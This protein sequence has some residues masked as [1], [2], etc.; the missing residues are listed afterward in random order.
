MNIL[1]AHYKRDDCQL[2]NQG[3]ILLDKGVHP[4]CIL[5]VEGCN[6]EDCA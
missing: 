3:F 4:H 5:G 6:V 1:K 2:P